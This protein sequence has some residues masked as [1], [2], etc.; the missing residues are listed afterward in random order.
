MLPESCKKN[1]KVSGQAG[2]L[3]MELHPWYGP[4]ALKLI[5]PIHE[6][7]EKNDAVFANSV[8]VLTQLTLIASIR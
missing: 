5:T 1:E 4:A 2:R 3:V 8:N 6:R 7:L